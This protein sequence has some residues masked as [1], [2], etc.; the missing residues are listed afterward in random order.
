[1]DVMDRN[2]RYILIAM[3]ILTMIFMVFCKYQASTIIAEPL[4]LPKSNRNGNRNVNRREHLVTSPVERVNKSCCLSDPKYRA[5]G[6]DNPFIF[7]YNYCINLSPSKLTNLPNWA[8]RV[9]MAQL[10]NLGFPG[11]IN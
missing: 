9:Q 10:S 6:Y 3:I 5:L 11:Y 7:P 8:R 4:V 1:M 2:T